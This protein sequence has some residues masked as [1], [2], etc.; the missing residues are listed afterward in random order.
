MSPEEKERII[1]SGQY[2]ECLW[3]EHNYEHGEGHGE[4]HYAR[5]TPEEE[6]EQREQLAQLHHNV[7]KQKGVEE[8]QKDMEEEK[9]HKDVAWQKHQEDEQQH[10]GQQNGY[11]QGQ[12]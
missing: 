11:Q 12:L 6:E 4:G 1:Q 3:G 10:Q 9:Q 5:A 2:S 7:D 8:H